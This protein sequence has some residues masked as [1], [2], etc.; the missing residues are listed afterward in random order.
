[1]GDLALLMG[2]YAGALQ[3]YERA[4][5]VFQAVGDLLGEA[6]CVKKLSDVA[7]RTANYTTAQLGYHKSL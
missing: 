4:L 6:S 5:S 1:M 2:N 3:N 7:F